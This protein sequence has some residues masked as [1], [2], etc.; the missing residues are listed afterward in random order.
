MEINKSPFGKLSNG[1]SVERFELK[2][3]NG[4]SVSIIT[5]G[6]IIQ[7]IHTPNEQ[8]VFKDI[9]LG[10]DDI[11]GYEQDQSSL[12]AVVGP[13]AGRIGDAKFTLGDQIY[14][15]TAND[16][17]NHLHGAEAGLGKKIWEAE[18][19]L[20]ANSAKLE[21]T[22]ES[23][24]GDGGY[25]G[26]RIFKTTYILNE[27][28]R[29][30]IYFEAESDQDTI[31]NMTNHS[32]FNLSDDET[33]VYTT[34]MMINSLKVLKKG[35]THIPNGEL[36][37]VLGKPSNFSRGAY[38]GAVIK[39]YEEGID[40]VYVV[41]KEKGEFKITAKAIDEKS[42]R[43][44]EVISDQDAVVLYTSNHFNGSEKGKNN[45]PL[46]RHCAFC[47]E[48]QSF[49]DAINHSHFPSIVVK[50]GEKYKSKIQ[51]NFGLMSDVHH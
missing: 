33:D 28:N 32:Y 43:V 19:H 10:K 46:I 8:G 21:L 16:G 3:N 50:A 13:V 48:S 6:A 41:N 22:T 37:Y 15:L 34:K 7:S 31:I 30:L 12:G 18:A 1:E 23:K 25:P 11:E 20:N 2:N 47:L 29:L 24:N 17:P 14:H 39:T 40:E 51:W 49:T 44:L 9:V 5:Y 38:L 42:G 26:N 4:V 35:K 36:D 27:Q 45:Q